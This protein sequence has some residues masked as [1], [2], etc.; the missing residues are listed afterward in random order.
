MAW[1]ELHQA[2]WTHRKTLLLAD[3]LGLK[4]AYA[5]SHV[6]HLWTWALDN[7]PH[8]DLSS[9]TARVI[10]VGGDWD[11]E[12]AVFVEALVV[13]GW[14]DRNGDQL[15]IHDWED[16]AGRLIRQREANAERMRQARGGA[17]PPSKGEDP[18]AKHVQRTFA[19]RAGADAH[20]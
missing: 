17:P 19:A 1:I 14:V 11:D 10:A 5:A 18:R 16:Y 6:I 2:V 3:A 9:L 20:A 7:A 12:P 8:G 4:A 15:C 13:S